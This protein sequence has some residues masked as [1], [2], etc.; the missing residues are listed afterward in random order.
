VFGLV[1]DRGLP[2]AVWVGVAFFQGLLILGALRVARLSR[3]VSGAAA[4]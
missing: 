2:A 4:A 3:P 1:M